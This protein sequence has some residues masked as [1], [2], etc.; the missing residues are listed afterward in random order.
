MYAQQ[1]TQKKLKLAGILAIAAGV[2]GI[3]LSS[4]VLLTFLSDFSVR[5]FSTI[6]FILIGVFIWATIASVLV[7]VGGIEAYTSP[8]IEHI[9]WGIMILLFSA[10]GLGPPAFIFINYGKGSLS[11]FS[12][13]GAIGG[14]LTCILGLLAAILGII[15]GILTLVIKPAPAPY[16]Q[17]YAQSGYPSPSQASYQQPYATQQQITKICPQCGRLVKENLKFCPNCGKILV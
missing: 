13:M 3:E 12:I 14:V 1:Q 6:D 11:S 17:E 8:P 5:S 9:K 16:K 2:I 7:L 15:G 4:D 10:A